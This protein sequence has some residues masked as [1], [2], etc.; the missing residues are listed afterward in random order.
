[1]VV[2]DGFEMWTARLLGRCWPIECLAMS[3][4]EE[5]IVSIFDEVQ[6]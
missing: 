5:H 6:V 2:R 4:V 1:M 3:S